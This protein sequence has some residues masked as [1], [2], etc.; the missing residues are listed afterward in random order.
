MPRKIKAQKLQEERE[1]VISK[2]Q[3]F[4]QDKKYEMFQQIPGLIDVSFVENPDPKILIKTVAE[5]DVENYDLAKGTGL[6]FEVKVMEAKD[7]QGKPVVMTDAGL[8]K[9]KLADSVDEKSE[10][11]TKKGLNDF[12][13][14]GVDKAGKTNMYKVEAQKEIIDVGLKPEDMVFKPGD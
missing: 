2:C 12:V 14:V 6:P 3:K 8:K 11:D 13:T 4:L 10:D 1:G 5:F 9:M 7:S